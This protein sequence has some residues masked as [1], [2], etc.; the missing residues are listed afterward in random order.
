MAP[1]RRQVPGQSRAPASAWARHDQLEHGI[2]NI[3]IR[4]NIYIPI[5][6][7]DKAALAEGKIASGSLASS[8]ILSM[9]HSACPVVQSRKAVLCQ[10]RSLGKMLLCSERKSNISAIIDMRYKQLNIHIRTSIW[11]P[12][13]CCEDT[14]TRRNNISVTRGLDFKLPVYRTPL[15]LKC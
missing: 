7:R 1:P 15:S 13:E 3:S 14:A 5:Q 9:D 8:K 6:P 2:A 12:K 11:F 10:G 4:R